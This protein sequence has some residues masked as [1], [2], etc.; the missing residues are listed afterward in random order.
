MA[1]RN[2]FEQTL[3]EDVQQNEHNTCPECGSRVTS[4]THETVCDDCGLVVEDQE[5]DRGREWREFNNDKGGRR[6]GAPNT[7]AR[8]DRGIG[9]DIGRK[10]DSRGRKI[11]GRKRRQLNRLRVNIP[12]RRSARRP[13]RTALL[14]SPRF[15]E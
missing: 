2:I 10:H 1:S 13:I 5:M 3:D 12:E 9:T 7:A 11:K 6:V 8:H 14:A 15:G 4:N